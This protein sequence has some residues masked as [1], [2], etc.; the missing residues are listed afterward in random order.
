M[1]GSAALKNRLGRDA[2]YHSSLVD[3]L[4]LRVGYPLRGL[5]KQAVTASSCRYS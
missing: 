3:A 5:T 4:L 2:P 1:L